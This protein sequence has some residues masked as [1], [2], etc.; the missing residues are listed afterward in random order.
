MFFGVVMN[1]H[2][3]IDFPPSAFPVGDQFRDA[4]KMMFRFVTRCFRRLNG[5]LN[6]GHEVFPAGVSQGLLKV[7]G[8]PEFDVAVIGKSLGQRIKVALHAVNLLDVHKDTGLKAMFGN[9]A[10]K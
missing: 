8:E 7:T 5:T 6:R 4:T 2:E 3:V 9:L 1:E 10:I